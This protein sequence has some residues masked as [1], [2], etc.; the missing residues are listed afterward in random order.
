MHQATKYPII[1]CPAP[2]MTQSDKWNKRPCVMRYFAFRDECKLLKVKLPVKAHITFIMPMP[3][4]WSGKKKDREDGQPHTCKP[5]LDNLL[6]ALLDAL[7]ADDGHI[8]DIRV[9]KI[10]G[11]EGAI[12]VD[13]M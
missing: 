10:W 13:S 9:N 4:S 6:K 7:Y 5:D 3:K 1:P 8:H 11:F 2:R 12:L